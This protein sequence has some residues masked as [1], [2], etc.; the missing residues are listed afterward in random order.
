[1]KTSV[2]I[3][4][5]IVV[6][7]LAG[8]V[9]YYAKICPPPSLC[10]P[11]PPAP[12]CPPPPKWG[13][14]L[15]AGFI[16]VGPIGDY[17]WTHAHDQGRKYVEKE[18]PWLKTMY[19][20]SVAEADAAKYIEDMLAKGAD[21]IFTTSF[22]YMDPTLEEAK[23]HPDKIFFHCSGYKRAANMGT[24]F[25]EFYQLYYLNGLMAGALTKT[26]KIGYV[27]AYTIPEVVR[28]INAFAIG[29]KEVNPNV[30]VYVR[31][32][33]AWYDPTK[34][35]EAAEALI[36]EGV[37][38]FAFTEDSPTVVQVAEEYYKKGK[39]IYVFG[40]YSPMKTYGPDVCVSGQIVHWEKIYE[41]ILAKIYLGVY[42]NTNLQN[43]DYWWMLHEGAVELGCWPGEPINPA[44]ADKL[45][46]VKVKEKIT[47]KEMSVYDLVML[48]LAQMSE[49]VPTFDP[50]TGPL[51]DNTGKLMAAPGERLGHDALWTIDWWMDNVVPPPAG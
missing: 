13:K 25:A 16:Y 32:I 46:A 2:W 11:C 42:T 30:K 37:D 49:E 17:G 7:I 38:V 34:A 29:A 15:T 45:K 8:V 36:A 28:H 35:R 26:N 6:A 18:F 9:G 40:H 22:G 14:N 43:V 23:K 27:A 47:G 44:I 5:L 33:H 51:Y 1:M 24:Y 21:V 31:E 12:T 3:V 10:P 39:P 4:V 20:E 41:D 19:A 48:R 50:F